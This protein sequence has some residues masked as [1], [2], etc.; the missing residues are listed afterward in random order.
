MRKVLFFLHSLYVTCDFSLCESEVCDA[1]LKGSGRS[2]N[3]SLF[4]LIICL[5]DMARQAH[6][7]IK[8]R[9]SLCVSFVCFIIFHC[10]CQFISKLIYLC[11]YCQFKYF[12]IHSPRVNAL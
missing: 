1:T 3:R 7:F 6:L 12:G 11:L 9:W 4:S 10:L 5:Q 2:E 8:C